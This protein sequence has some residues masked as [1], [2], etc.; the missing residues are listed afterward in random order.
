M[1]TGLKGGGYLPQ[2]NFSFD[3][4]DE[5]EKQSLY[6]EKPVLASNS[7]LLGKIKE[8]PNIL[9]ELVKRVTK[10]FYDFKI[11]KDKTSDV[12][13]ET[14]LYY[15]KF[16]DVTDMIKDIFGER[17]NMYHLAKII[18]GEDHIDV[19]Y[20]RSTKDV[21]EFASNSL[22]YTQIE[23]IANHFGIKYDEDEHDTEE[24]LLK[25]MIEE[26]A[27]VESL[28]D[29]ALFRGDETG[30]MDDAYDKFKN[31][32]SFEFLN[33]TFTI[34]EDHETPRI[35]ISLKDAIELMGKPEFQ[36]YTDEEHGEFYIMN[37][38]DL[39][40]DLSDID[41]QT[42]SYI[43]GFSEESFFEYFNEEGVEL[44]KR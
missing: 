28:L 2:N 41:D 23:A 15:D 17:S 21:I 13:L 16:T 39:Y 31:N 35:E 29:M 24:K 5:R 36:E 34:V 42:M 14:K 43:E 6:E 25:F 30:Y 3:D 18:N 27:E 1:I 38:S 11:S 8:D 22:S 12:S 7:F 26:N 9:P 33:K 37:T 40:F 4:L 20:D 19:W 44:P 10:V 32:L